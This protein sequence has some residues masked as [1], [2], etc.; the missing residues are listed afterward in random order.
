MIISLL[1]QVPFF[2]EDLR[3]QMPQKVK[4]K[5]KKTLSKTRGQRDTQG[6]GV[7]KLTRGGKNR[8]WGGDWRKRPS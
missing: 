8:A 4:K 7:G 1:F 2:G 5:K 3:N 6:S